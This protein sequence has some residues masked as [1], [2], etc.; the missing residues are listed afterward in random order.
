[1]DGLESLIYYIY[2]I[3]QNAAVAVYHF[4]LTN[5]AFC[6]LLFCMFYVFNKQ[7]ILVERETIRPIRRSMSSSPYHPQQKQ[8]GGLSEDIV[9]A[10]LSKER[11][12]LIAL[13]GVIFGTILICFF[14][15]TTVVLYMITAMWIV[16]AL[17]VRLM[18]GDRKEMS[19]SIQN[20]SLGYTIMLILL[21]I[22]IGIV[23]NTPASEWS[24]SLG[25]TLPASAVGTLS[26]YLPMMFLIMTFGIPLAYFRVV[27][28]KW[29][30]AKNNKDVSRRRSEIMRTGNQDMLQ[31]YDDMMYKNNNMF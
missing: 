1:M 5:L 12:K 22:L 31:S 23:V 4:L 16:G 14:F 8:W 10:T 26:G 15:A 17:S 9:L 30:I 24:R 7:N 18:E 3:H 27:A 2:I 29:T 25:V 21:K 6:L 13:Y 20:Y 19:E 11:I 28:Q